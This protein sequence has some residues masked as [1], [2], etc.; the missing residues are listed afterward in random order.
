MRTTAITNHRPSLVNNRGVA[1]LHIVMVL[2]FIGAVI[3]IAALIAGPLS[4]RIKS[5][6][7]IGIIDAGIE[8]L[9]G[10]A[11]TNRRL[12]TAAQFTSVVQKAND[13]WGNPLYYIVDP[14]L[15]PASPAASC[16]WA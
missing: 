8:S 10:Y 5:N 12:P 15:A 1:L 13:A 6:E 9:A 7:T 16:C 11:S 4:K 14:D 2:I 3:G